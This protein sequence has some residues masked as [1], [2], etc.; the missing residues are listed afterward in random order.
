[1]LQILVLALLF[2]WLVYAIISHRLS[3]KEKTS[4]YSCPPVHFSWIPFVGHIFG[5]ATKGSNLYISSLWYLNLPLRY[6]IYLAY[7]KVSQ[8]DPTL[9][10][11]NSE[12]PRNGHALDSPAGLG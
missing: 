2:V 5:I 11:G 1:M 3:S 12:T 9:V 8:F 10:D 4:T 6:I 7:T